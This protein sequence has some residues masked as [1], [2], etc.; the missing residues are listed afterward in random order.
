MTT[1]SSSTTV[2]INLKPASYTSPVVIEAGVTISN[3]NY[4]HAV[5][6]DPG[7]TVV[8]NIENNGTITGPA[9]GI[10]VYLAPG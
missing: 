4:P 6:T 5:Y 8:F 10:G 3:P 7:S 1:I 2:G 9:A